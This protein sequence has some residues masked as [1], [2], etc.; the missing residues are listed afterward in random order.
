MRAQLDAVVA[1]QASSAAAAVQKQSRSGAP[2]PAAPSALHLA[3]LQ[4]LLASV[5]APCRH[6]PPFLPHAMHLFSQV[7]CRPSVLTTLFQ[8]LA[9]RPV[10]LHP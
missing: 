2:T 5:L 4:A 1:H 8:F 10:L 6:A 3:A 9:R 7:S